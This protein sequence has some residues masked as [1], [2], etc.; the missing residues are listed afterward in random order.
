MGYYDDPPIIVMKYYELGTLE[1]WILNND[2]CPASQWTETFIHRIATNIANALNEL[3]KKRMYHRD[4]KPQ[5][6]FMEIDGTGEI[7]AVL[8]DFGSTLVSDDRLLGVAAL[9]PLNPDALSIPFAAPELLIAWRD[10]AIGRITPK[11]FE[12]IDIYAFALTLFELL[13]RGYA[14]GPVSTKKIIALVLDGKR[15]DFPY[16]LSTHNFVV[17]FRNIISSCWA[18]E[19]RPTISEVLVR[20]QQ[21]VPSNCTYIVQK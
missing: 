4:I 18:E 5:N 10:K 2:K 8:G 14:W 16:T 19:I 17:G 7:N 21:L 20:L 9:K 12:K 3:H 15:P 13:I 1:D 11:A 6:V